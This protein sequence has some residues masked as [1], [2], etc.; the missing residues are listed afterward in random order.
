MKDGTLLLIAQE[1]KVL[2]EN[3]M[4][5]GMPTNQ[6]TQKKFLGRHKHRN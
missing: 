6:V 1:K 5:G 4:N 2:Q 3:T